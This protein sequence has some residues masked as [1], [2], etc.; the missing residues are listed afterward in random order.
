MK[1]Q[2]LKMEHR[3]GSGR[4]RLGDFYAES[5]LFHF[6]ENSDYLRK[7]GV[8]DESDPAD[9]KVI[10]PNYLASP[11]NCVS[12]SGYYEI[13]C[14]DECEDL[15]DKVE[16]KLEAPM[17]TPEAIASVVTAFR[18]SSTA[19]S[20]SLPAE[21]MELLHQVAGHHGGM[22]PIH[23]RLFSQWMHQ[24]FPRE[25]MHPSRTTED[26][27]N[28][29]YL[30]SEVAQS[31]RQNFAD[32]AKVQEGLTPKETEADWHVPTSIWTMDETLVDAKTYQTHTKTWGMRDILAFSV[33]GFTAMVMT[34]LLFGYGDS[35]L[36]TKRG[37][38]L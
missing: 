25:C 26:R 35:R 17:G 7:A 23:G 16:A 3:P 6:R 37:K 14:F 13:C 9:P 8:L 5:E 28:L 11:S 10:I 34:K 30:N 18:P 2:L 24:A 29:Y 21:L 1:T 4:V 12:P 15:M 32:I 38:E 19:G 31:E 27:Y 36:G 22:V 33:V 20:T